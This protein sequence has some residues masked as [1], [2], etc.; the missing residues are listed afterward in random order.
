MLSGRESGYWTQPV[1]DNGFTVRPASLAEYLP[2]IWLVY[3][4]IDNGLSAGIWTQNL[5]IPNQVLYQIELR[6]DIFGDATGTRTR[7]A[8]VKGRCPDR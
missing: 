5:L 2:L 3:S 7:I 1:L 6:P 8:A 4:H